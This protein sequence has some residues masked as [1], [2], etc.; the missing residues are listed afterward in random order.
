MCFI[1]YILKKVKAIILIFYKFINRTG[2]IIIYMLV[3]PFIVI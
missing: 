2:S 1:Y 3:S